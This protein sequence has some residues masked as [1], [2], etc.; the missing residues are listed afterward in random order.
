MSSP[1]NFV[2]LKPRS[3]SFGD[4]ATLPLAATTALQA[5]RKYPGTLEGKTVFIPGGCKQS[6]FSVNGGVLISFLTVSATGS[7][8]CQLAKNEFHAGKVITTVS[9]AK[10]GKVATLLGEGVVDQGQYLTYIRLQV[11]KAIS[12][13]DYTKDDPTKVI[14]PRSVDFVFDTTGQAMEFLSLMVPSTS[15]IIS[16]ATQPSGTTLQNS[17]VM[18]RADNPRLPWFVYLAL[19]V[20]DAIRKLRARRWNVQYEYLFLNP[21][22]A[23]LESLSR[24]VESGKLRA[25]VGTRVNFRDIEGLK[26]ACNVVYKGKGGIGKTVVEVIQS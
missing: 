21:N 1:E 23:D 20:G 14:P 26:D 24:S 16:I 6:E 17:S 5:L 9:T 15:A 4:A 10:V 19:N 11:P 12:V 13:I 25:V 7:F 8:A 22:A 18:K 2:A 3:L